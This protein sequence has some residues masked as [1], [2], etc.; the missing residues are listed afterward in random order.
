MLLVLAALF[1]ACLGGSPSDDM[2][3]KEAVDRAKDKAADLAAET[4]AQKAKAEAKKASQELV[5]FKC[6]M[7]DGT[8]MYFLKGKGK[9]TSPGGNTYLDNEGVYTVMDAG[10]EQ[11]LV[12]FPV[13]EATMDMDDMKAAYESSKVTDTY[14]CELNVVSEADVAMPD[15]PIM[16]MDEYQARLMEGLGNMGMTPPMG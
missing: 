12:K 1:T 11:V 10:G 13:E 3:G 14:D 15:M 6:T 5:N 2:S 8:T 9:V 16:T 7:A 4:A